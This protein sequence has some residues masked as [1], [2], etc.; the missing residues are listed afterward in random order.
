MS[1]RDLLRALE[2]AERSL[3]NDMPADAARRVRARLSKPRRHIARRPLLL[4]LGATAA[5]TVAALILVLWPASAPRAPAPARLAGMLLASQTPELQ[6]RAHGG[7]IIEI[8]AGE[9]VLADEASGVTVALVAPAAIGPTSDG[10]RVLHGRA[11][12]HVAKRAPPQAPVR[13][14]VS[15][16]VIEVVGTVFTIVQRPR[17]G[18]VHLQEGS[19]RFL[20]PSGA[21]YVLAPGDAHAWP[22]APAPAPPPVPG[23]RIAPQTPPEESDSSPAVLLS[24]GYI[25]G[26]AIAGILIAALAIIP[27][28]A[29][30]LDLSR[31]LPSAWNDSPWPALAAFGAMTLL[32]FLVGIGVLLKSSDSLKTSGTHQEL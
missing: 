2:D 4:G 30:T 32:L 12:V 22:A 21:S 7:N 28:A 26:G 17:D 6:A 11:V 24:S 10:L 19:I 20:H 8:S 3:P 9:C 15:H 23:L 13:V 31:H 27:G 29:T 5:A 25:A 16:G 18:E 1:N 14:H